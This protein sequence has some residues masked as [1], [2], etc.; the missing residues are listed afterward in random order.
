M[1]Y[2]AWILGAVIAAL[3]WA[4]S[5]EWIKAHE[6]FERTEYTRSL[7]I[8]L[9]AK[10][11]TASSFLLIGKNY[12]MLAEYK[13]ATDYLEKA[14]SLQPDSAE[15][16]LWLG[17]AYGRRAEFASPFT[18]PGLASKSR[19][20]LERAVALK[21]DDREAIG[22]LFDYYLEAP[23]FLGGGQSKA[24]AL[25][26]KVAAIDPAEGHYYQ[27]I[28]ADRR[29][30][31]DVAER[32]FRA[33][34]ELAPRQVSRVIDLAKYLGL[35]GRMNESEA[36]FEEAIRI[37]PNNPRILFE[38]ASL[39]IKEHRNLGEARK[40]LERYLQSP[41]KP[42][43]PPRQEAEALLKKIGA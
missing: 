1:N 23:G 22:D 19:Q 41:L 26:A 39:Y 8:L 32:H 42:D 21:P 43:D 3:G 17:R 15:T 30:Q 14:L 13:K 24:E 5:V 11:N 9:A 31:Y 20:M 12:F 4:E 25:A 27:A 36:L 16:L 29:K 40:L 34:M 2:R 6:L 28:L 7:E 18:A 10:E 33:A 35:R 37:D 38:R